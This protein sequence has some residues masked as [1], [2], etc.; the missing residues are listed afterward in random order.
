[1]FWFKKK[2]IVLDCF[3]AEVFTEEYCKPREASKF[4]PEWYKG[5]PSKYIATNKK[6]G[7]DYKEHVTLKH[8]HAF[9]ELYKNSIILP[10]WSNLSLKVGSS[11]FIQ[12]TNRAE[13]MKFGIHDPEQTDNIFLKNKIQHIKLNSPWH[14]RTNKLVNFTWID[15]FWN[16]IDQNSDKE[17]TILP[18]LIE[19]RYQTGTEVNL[20]FSTS[21][22]KRVINISTGEPLVMLVPNTDEQII[23]K[24]HLIGPNEWHKFDGG[25][26]FFNLNKGAYDASIMYYKA[27]KEFLQKHY[28]REEEPAS[29]CP[30]GFKKK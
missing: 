18:G 11:M 25:G 21:G 20:V 17:F 1:M 2:E 29:K 22:E 6:Y 27:K 26:K 15:P 13:D 30:F 23:I 9:T 28:E 19:F 14:F 4:Y 12:D 7:A 8:C 10:A 16:K 24:T 3:T 5:L